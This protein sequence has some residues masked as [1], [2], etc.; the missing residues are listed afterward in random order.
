MEV[1]IEEYMYLTDEE[2]VYMM[3]HPPLQDQEMSDPEDIVLYNRVFEVNFRLSTGYRV[4]EH[5]G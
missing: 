5:H 3:E 1:S 2:R 4:G